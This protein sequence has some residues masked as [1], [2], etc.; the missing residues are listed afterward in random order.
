MLK[1][2]SAKRL[3]AAVLIQKSF[4]GY[5][6]RANFFDL[7]RII[8]VQSLVRRVVPKKSA[9]KHISAVSLIQA[10]FRNLFA[11]KEIENGAATKIQAQYRSHLTEERYLDTLADVVILQSIIRRWIVTALI[12]PKLRYEKDKM[13]RGHKISTDSKEKN[14]ECNPLSNDIADSNLDK[15]CCDVLGRDAT[16]SKDKRFG[17]VQSKKYT[18]FSESMMNKISGSLIISPEEKKILRQR[19]NSAT[20]FWVEKISKQSSPLFPPVS[21]RLD[22]F[23]GF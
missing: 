5:L 11:K 21:G 13:K 15:K 8:L 2:F 7:S 19:K 10:S 3:A 22:Y 23:S 20:T 6:A 16:S 18:A 9:A 12:L 4:K 17:Y 14:T 1:K